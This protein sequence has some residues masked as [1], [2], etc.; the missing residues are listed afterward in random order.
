MGVLND[1]MS[2]TFNLAFSTPDEQ[3]CFA[4]MAA[5]CIYSMMRYFNKHIFEPPF[6]FRVKTIYFVAIV[7]SKIDCHQ[8]CNLLR[9]L[10]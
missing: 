8:R 6:N 10:W 2:Y 1:G 9:C 3:S 5:H 4:W 7:L